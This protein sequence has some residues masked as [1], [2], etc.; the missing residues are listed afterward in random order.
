MSLQSAEKPNY[1]LAGSELPI[2]LYVGGL[3]KVIWDKVE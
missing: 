3:W 1:V 2:F